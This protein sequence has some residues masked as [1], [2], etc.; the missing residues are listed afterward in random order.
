M[1]GAD[2]PDTYIK[3]KKKSQ[4]VSFEKKT[5]DDDEYYRIELSGF[6]WAVFYWRPNMPYVLPS[7][8]PYSASCS[9]ERPYGYSYENKITI[10]DYERDFN[11]VE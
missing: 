11:I 8:E 10:E 1:E 3:E 6:S 7:M 2:W 5:E 9:F 4:I